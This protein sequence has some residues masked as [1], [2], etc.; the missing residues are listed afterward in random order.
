MKV[1]NMRVTKGNESQQVVS[2]VMSVSDEKFSTLSAE[3]LAY[4]FKIDRSKLSRLFKHQRN[5]TLR[6]FIFKE[7]MSRASY[8]LRINL[9][10]TVQ[11]VS[12][13]I[14]FANCDYFTRRFKEHY[15]VAPGMYKK[16]KS[17]R[18]GGTNKLMP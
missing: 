4:F 9:N 14:G 13:R 5:I 15:G 6:E 16:L 7:R 3:V 1:T 18:S 8:L 10:I 17:W 2:Y 12:Q 11:E